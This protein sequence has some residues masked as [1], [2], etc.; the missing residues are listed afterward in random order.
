MKKVDV[1]IPVRNEESNVA[2]LAAS[3]NRTLAQVTDKYKLIF[4]VDP[5]TDNTA[6]ILEELK[7]TYPIYI[8]YKKGLPG[9]GYSLIEGIMLS[10]AD[11]VA[12][13]DGDLQY[14]PEALQEM[15]HVMEDETVGVVVANRKKYHSN[16]LRRAGSRLN[17]L[18][19]GKLLLGLDCDIQSGLKIFRR[20]IFDHVDI[21]TIGPWTFDIP[22]LHTAVRLGYTIGKV[23]IEYTL[24]NGGT[25]K[26]RFMK[27]AYSIAECALKTASNSHKVYHLDDHRNVHG[28]ILFKKQKFTPHTLLPHHKSAIYTT[29]KTQKYVIVG[30]L[31]AAITGLVLA[32]LQVAIFLIA[33][34]SVI[35]FSDVLFS[36]YLILKSLHFP[37]EISFTKDQID[38]V[39]DEELPVY[40][41]MC[42]LY[43]EAHVL[44]QFVEAMNNMDYPK[45]KMDVLILLE[46]ND[47]ET[48][49]VAESL[50][51]PK[52][53]RIIV[54]P[55]S[56]PKT[57]PKACNYGIHY[58]LG[59]Y[60]VVYDAEDIPETT[61]LKKGYLAFKQVKPNV[62]CIQAKLNYYNPKQNLLTTMFTAEYSLW[63]DVILPGLQSINTIIPLGGTSNHFRTKDLINLHSWDPFNVTE[64]CDLGVRLF[65]DGYKTE[66]M[67]SVTL[68]EANSDVKNWIR[69]RSR[70]IKGYLQTYLVHMRDPV[71]FIREHKWHA[72]V[73][74]LI[75]GLRISFIL[76][77]PIL[78]AAT[79]SYFALYQYVG[80]AIEAVYPTP[81]FY[82][83]A[84][85][86][87]FGNFIYLYN[88]MIGLAKRGHWEVIKYV[89]LVPFYWA[90]MGISA[91]VAFHQLIF[92][93]H[94]WEKTHHGLHIKKN[95]FK[96]VSSKPLNISPI[97]ILGH[98]ITP[99]QLSGSILVFSTVFANFA[100]F[101]YNAYLGR[102]VDIAQFGTVSLIS[103]IFAISAVFSSTLGK[104]TSYKT[105]LTFGHLKV[106]NKDF[107]FSMQKTAWLMSIL[108]TGIWILS[109]PFLSRFFN[110]QEITPLLLFTPYWM[111]S[112]VGSINSGFLSG[113]HKFAV[114]GVGMFIESVSKVLLAILAVESGYSNLVFAVI[115]ASALIVFI[116]EY[117]F[118]YKTDSKQT[119]ERVDISFPF[120]YWFTSILTKVSTVIFLSADVIL[121][122]HYLNPVDA[123]RYALLSLAG[124]IVYFLGNL[125]AQFIVPVVSKEEGSK[126]KSPRTF[127]WLFAG[128]T[129]LSL[130]GFVGI[131]LLGKITTPLLFGDKVLPITNMLA[132]YTLA[133]LIFSISFAIVS[134]HQIRKRYIFTLVP[135]IFA[136][137]EVILISRLAHSIER[138]VNVIVV[139]SLYQ[140]GVVLF[141]HLFLD[142]IL[143]FAAKTRKKYFPNVSHSHQNKLRILIFNWRDIKHVWA[144]GAEVYV[145]E[146]AKVWVKK[147][148]SVTI[149]CG[150]D[151]KNNSR[152]NYDGINVIRKGGFF[153]VYFW[154]FLYYVFKLRKQFD[155]IVDSENGI[156]FFTP[157]FTRKPVILLIHHIHKDIVLN[158]LKLPKYLLPVAFIVK[159]LETYL[160]PL[161]YRN[162]EIVAVSD[163]TKTDLINLKFKNEIEVVNPGVDLDKF[164]KSE[165]TTDPSILYLGRIKHYKCLDTLIRA[166]K[167]VV[168]NIPNAKLIIAGF[169]EARKN[170]E[171]LTL[172][173]GLNEKVEFLGKVTE[174]DKVNLMAQSWVFAYPSSMEGWGISIIE[175][176]ASG[177]AIVASDVPGLR[178]SVK[179]PH[180]GYL[181]ELNNHDKFAES[182][183]NIIKDNDLRKNLELEGVKWAKNFSWNSSADKFMK[184]IK[185]TY[186]NERVKLL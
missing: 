37:P 178:D 55:H 2:K 122:K 115:P 67:D 181:I 168:E 19:F 129:L 90:M 152:D 125:L 13:I 46:A 87:V 59:D 126:I 79:I 77:N 9:K 40:S 43:K 39:T 128:T 95:A 34:L 140:L 18:I 4:V 119:Q 110:E 85:S 25:S 102:Q 21:T 83:A 66:I 60:M 136:V 107:Y 150:N 146:L 134:Y 78:W 153:T 145:H 116:Y 51:L 132:P 114:L 31:I 173:L 98:T 123:G 96:Q 82:M 131:G 44:P 91:L 161:I 185:R 142:T 27:T 69:Q 89:F 8:H 81:V 38:A 6:N 156:P 75:I 88:Y 5:S 7:N 24:R 120:R 22:L 149:F 138:F 80:P 94:F 53:F 63:F 15:V 171:E 84:F 155:L 29:I 93:P 10:D 56:M 65:K 148:H 36:V 62:I 179:N 1:V 86:L 175:A 137:L 54:V 3:L 52:Y 68:E 166:H 127:Y 157:L 160:M 112:F 124:K 58:A 183:L 45:D 162:T 76:I 154:G 167:N 97:K 100:N 144:G 32:P 12:F 141:M 130:S 16:F 184:I 70:W 35:Y 42:P 20:R 108:A 72:L 49:A 26:V 174:E 170:L 23:D 133:M 177:T 106:L 11:L 99:A 64:D 33:I 47:T 169:G 121:A 101:V 111:I 186:E 147:G 104:A 41:V 135:F 159:N 48:I 182:I 74:Q 57:K 151:G 172:K 113:S 92:K 17:K 14:P 163:S 158:A 73:F 71:S 117:I 103:N 61:Q 164:R 105:A 30:V 50:N 118:V 180:T 139:L 165:K 143:D 109:I 176:S 28:E